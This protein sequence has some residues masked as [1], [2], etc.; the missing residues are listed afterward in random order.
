MQQGMPPELKADIEAKEAAKKKEQRILEKQNFI[1]GCDEM[2]RI[3]DDIIVPVFVRLAKSLNKLDKEIDLVL[4]DCESPFDKQLYNVGVR[5]S[6][7]DQVISIVADP[8]AFTFTL[9]LPDNSEE[10]IDFYEL[11]PRSLEKSL[12]NYLSSNVPSVNYSVYPDP[13]QETFEQFEA[14]FRVRYD[15][16]GNVSDVATTKTLKEAASMGNTFA[17]MF[18][19]EEAVSIVDAKDTLI[20]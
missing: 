3:T 1:L 14:P 6:I 10:A 2:E 5:L 20:C 17:K 15:D 13:N 9:S 16:D 7:E 11:T 12:V 8:S 19:K 4:M 18:K